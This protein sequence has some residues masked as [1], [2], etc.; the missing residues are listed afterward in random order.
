MGH[1][2]VELGALRLEPAGSDQWVVAAEFSHLLNPGRPIDPGA[3]R[4]HGLRQADLIGQPS[5]ADIF[6]QLQAFTRGALLVAHN[7]RFDAGFIGH[8]FGLLGDPPPTNPWLCTMLLAR[9]HFFFGRN[10]LA[11]VARQLGVPQGR[12]HRALNDA[13]TT[14]QV[15]QRMVAS[16]A[17]LRLETV[18]DFLAAQGGPIFAQPTGTVKPDQDLNRLGREL[19]EAITA[20]RSVWISY[21]G[22]SGNTERIVEPVELSQRRGTLYLVAHCRLRGARRTFRVDRILRHVVHRK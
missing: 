9:R 1:R 18:G 20:R 2:V 8:E 22:A 3:Q 21:A 5:F 6:E 14:A 15:L 19:A 12:A 16:L 4:V 11:N 7:A 10:S 17:E 13:Y